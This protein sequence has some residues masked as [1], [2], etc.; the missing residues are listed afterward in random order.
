MDFETVVP[1]L[2]R[3]GLQRI[4]SGVHAP[5]A[6]EVHLHRL[7]DMHPEIED[8]PIKNP[9]FVLGLNCTGTTFLHRLLEASVCFEA[10]H[11]E[12]QQLLPA[13]EQMANPK[14][15]AEN[16]RLEFFD[17][18]LGF[19]KSSTRGIHEIQ[20]GVAEE[21]MCALPRW[22]KTYFLTHQGLESGPSNC[23]NTEECI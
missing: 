10:P 15:D 21:D 14:A 17:N 13:A 22:G 2:V 20:L 8:E 19:L 1:P 23:C 7:L 5:T 4:C 12:K 11:M 6:R 3:E 16:E 18:F 9:V